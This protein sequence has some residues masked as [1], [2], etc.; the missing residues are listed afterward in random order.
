MIKKT[1][2]NNSNDYNEAKDIA[3]SIT[4]TPLIRSYRIHAYMF[5][6]MQNHPTFLNYVISNYLCLHNKQNNR[7]YLDFHLDNY[8]C[9]M[10]SL[11][12]D[13]SWFEIKQVDISS[14]EFKNPEAIKQTI[15][16]HLNQ[17][18]Y[19]IHRVNEA[20]LPHTNYYGENCINNNEM[21][22][23][24]SQ[25]CDSF[26]V[27]DYNQNGQFCSSLV[28]SND[29]LKAIKITM[30]P[31]Y[32]N[33]IKAKKE[34]DFCFD[35][36]RALKLLRCH[37]DSITAYPEYKDFSNNLVGYR[38]VNRS[39][40]NMKNEGYDFIRLRV[41]KEHKNIVL[42][43]FEYTC[44]NGIDDPYF[45]EQYKII[46]KMMETIF[47]C[48]IRDAMNNAS[49]QTIINRINSIIELNEKESQLI[50]RYLTKY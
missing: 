37:M 48:A 18:Y 36:P 41:I 1:L 4:T 6:L 12:H 24:Y 33:F 30:S 11:F 19:A 23:G 46:D 42:R 2:S 13:N 38:A 5:N 7:D 15:L 14:D 8:F 47:M 28:N 3:L 29:Y 43:Y 22:F 27:L 49:Q 16:E 26:F 40:E 34:I 44:A 17:G 35:Q 39:L 32:L 10:S 25:R 45:L 9:N 50:S 31:I 21:T 20:Y